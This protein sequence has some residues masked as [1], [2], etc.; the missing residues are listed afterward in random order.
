MEDILLE[1]M[2]DLP[3]MTHVDKVVVNEEAAQKGAKPLLLFADG[4][5]EA[6]AG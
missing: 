6:S 2:F 3:S 5:K 4:K 1:T